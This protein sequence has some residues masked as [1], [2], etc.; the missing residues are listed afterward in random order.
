MTTVRNLYKDLSSGHASPSP[1]EMPETKGT[2][3]K[4]LKTDALESADPVDLDEDDDGVSFM[5]TILKVLRSPTL[6]KL[7]V[8]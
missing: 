8:F 3:D 7:L 5:L 6:V 1:P 2:F 4:P